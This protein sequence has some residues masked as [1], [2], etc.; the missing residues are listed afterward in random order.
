MRTIRLRYPARCADCGAELPQG[1]KA[2]YY[3]PRR[4][5]GIGCH[6]NGNGE[7]DDDGL[8]AGMRRDTDGTPMALVYPYQGARR[9][10]WRRGYSATGIRCEDAPCC[11]CCS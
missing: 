10:E 3:G 11:G 4:V 6:A 1:A 7:A 9:P 2:K 5:Y 8:P